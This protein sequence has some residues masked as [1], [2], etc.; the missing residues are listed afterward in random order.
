M[1]E[2]QFW[3]RGVEEKAR[4]DGARYWGRHGGVRTGFVSGGRIEDGEG[5]LRRGRGAESDS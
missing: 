1:G 3:R 2:S 4:M 5:H